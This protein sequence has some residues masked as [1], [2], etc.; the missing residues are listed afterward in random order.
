MNGIE[1]SLT[2]DEVNQVLEALGQQPYALVHLLIGKIH[3]QAAA[4]LSEENGGAAAPEPP[5]HLPERT[6]S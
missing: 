4:Q 3:R 2:L 6:A 5:A 1:L